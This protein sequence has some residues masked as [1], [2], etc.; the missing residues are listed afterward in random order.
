[1]SLKENDRFNDLPIDIMNIIFRM[2]GWRYMV[3]LSR[4][5][6]TWNN[7]FWSPVFWKGMK[8]CASIGDKS[9]FISLMTSSYNIF[10]EKVNNL[11]LMEFCDNIELSGCIDVSFKLSPK[12]IELEL[13]NLKYFSNFKFENVEGVILKCDLEILKRHS[14]IFPNLLD[15]SFICYHETFKQ[16]ET[17]FDQIV[18]NS[19]NGPF[20]CTYEGSKQKEITFGQIIPKKN[21]G[22]WSPY[23]T[24]YVFPRLK[25]I[26][27]G[28]CEKENESF[29]ILK[30]QRDQKLKFHKFSSIDYVKLSLLTADKFCQ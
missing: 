29:V 18:P 27:I 9:I 14:E 2:V 1:M 15:G 26:F 20:I 19:L 24:G 5:C 22:K 12:K 4:V 28:I 8:I 10:F 25:L 11:N 23:Y 6:K 17:T 16:R 7:V 21:M 3:I 13:D 30:E